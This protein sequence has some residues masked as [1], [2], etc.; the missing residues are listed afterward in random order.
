MREL[1]AEHRL[2]LHVLEPHADGA[3]D[4][5]PVIDGRPLGK[6]TLP[7]LAGRMFPG[8]RLHLTHG[9]DGANDLP[10]MVEEQVLPLTAANCPAPAEVARSRGGIVA[11]RSA[12]EGG[13]VVECY[14][15]LARRGWYGPLSPA[16]YAICE[17]CLDE[18]GKP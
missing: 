13:A 16:V 9:G 2:A 15:E 11:R 14:H 17:R 10:A 18:G 4:V 5:V 8:T 3:L 7:T 6:W 12:P 1:I